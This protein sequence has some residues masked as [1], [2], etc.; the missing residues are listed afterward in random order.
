M[1][2]LIVTAG[3]SLLTKPIWLEFVNYGLSIFNAHHK[4]L[5]LSIIGEWDSLVGLA[6][7]FGALIWNTINR[8]IDLNTEQKSEPAYKG[9]KAKRYNSFEDLSNDIYLLLKDNDQIFK[10][11]GPNS[12]ATTTEELRTDLTMWY[13]Y[14]NQSIIP[15]NQKIKEILQNNIDILNNGQR[16]LAQRM[17]LHIDAFE[18]HV[19]NPEFDYSQFRFPVDFR[20]L[21]EITCFENAKH[22]KTLKKE[23]E[24]L[25]KN[26]AKLSVRRWYLFG[27][28]ILTPDI[29]KD[30]DA[31]ILMDYDNSLS[32][33]IEIIKFDF[34]LKFKR[35]LHL[36]IF[37]NDEMLSFE[38]F[39]DQ[40]EFKLEG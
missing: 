2:Y 9:V 29:S 11:V 17:I 27:S 10:S 8:L 36:T 30:V 21:I 26:F 3:L 32:R 40:N 13:K 37:N 35:G 19:K 4:E 39:I 38:G 14:R 34:K 22:S 15:N 24:W 5:N 16:T 7:I 31:V 23:V 12:G 1:T 25:K 18:E 6:L 33:K 28:S 20:N